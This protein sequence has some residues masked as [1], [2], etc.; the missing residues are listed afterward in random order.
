VIVP[1][2]TPP[3]DNVVQQGAE[4]GKACAPEGAAG[5]TGDATPV[6][7]VRGQDGTLLWQLS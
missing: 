4:V 7:C 2:L 3:P 6:R 5:E 1:Q